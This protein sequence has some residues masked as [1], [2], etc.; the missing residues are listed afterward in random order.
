M[1]TPD[2]ILSGQVRAGAEL[3]RRN[4]FQARAAQPVRLTPDRIRAIWRRELPR[5]N[6]DRL[7]ICDALL[8]FTESLAVFLADTGPAGPVAAAQRLTDLK[9]S[10]VP[11]LR[12]AD[13]LRARLDSPNS[14]FRLVHTSDAVAELVR[15]SGILFTAPERH[16]ALAD[17]RR[18]RD[19]GSEDLG[20]VA[21][22]LAGRPRERP[23]DTAAALRRADAVVHAA[24][25]RVPDD[26]GLEALR[27][28]FARLAEGL[29][30]S[31]RHL[32]AVAARAPARIEDWDLIALAA[33][34]VSANRR[35]PSDGG[36]AR[37]AQSASA[38][39][40]RRT[41]TYSPAAP[42]SARYAA[43]ASSPAPT[44]PSAGSRSRSIAWYRGRQ[45][46]IAWTAPG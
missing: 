16:R 28:Q 17:L 37:R 18:G 40:R 29:V 9:G 39:P 34:A 30:V 21:H 43:G 33:E 26:P 27:D 2:C 44:S 46:T 35:R 3:L 1:F 23:L 25:Q 8:P 20:R 41:A 5:T 42:T 7:A 10:G 45:R 38:L 12:G 22:A 11:G 31:A 24:Q 36:R 6:P 13:T 4:G 32:F 19:L 14:V 15:E